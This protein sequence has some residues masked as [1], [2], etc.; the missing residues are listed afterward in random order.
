VG[1]ALTHKAGNKHTGDSLFPHLLDL[2]L[3]AGCNGSAHHCQCIDMG[4][5]AD[6]GSCEPRQ[7]KQPTETTQGADQQQVE[8]EARALEQPPRFLAND[9]PARRTGSRGWQAGLQ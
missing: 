3:V 6:S 2:G 7:P 1:Q 8:M 9:E 4:N 5:G